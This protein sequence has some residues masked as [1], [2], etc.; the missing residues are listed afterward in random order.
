MSKSKQRES[1]SAGA[2]PTAKQLLADGKGPKLT[3]ISGETSESQ[4]K[5]PK[6]SYIHAASGLHDGQKAG[7]IMKNRF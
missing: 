5:S 7:Y 4:L 2:R 1:E 3:A 6:G